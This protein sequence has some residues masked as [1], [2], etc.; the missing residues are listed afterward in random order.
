MVKLKVVIKKNINCKIKVVLR[1]NTNN[2]LTL[3]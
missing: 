3:C 2:K 1:T